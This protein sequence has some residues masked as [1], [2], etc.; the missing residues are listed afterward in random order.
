MGSRK[1]H[2]PSSARLSGPALF[3]AKRIRLLSLDP[4]P[5]DVHEGVVA[6]KVFVLRPGVSHH[7]SKRAV[8]DVSGALYAQAVLEERCAKLDEIP[9]VQLIQAHMA[10]PPQDMFA[11][12]LA[13]VTFLRGT[14]A[15]VFVMIHRS[16]YAPTV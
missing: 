2:F 9:S 15:G 12:V 7:G 16:K 4:W 1:N 10:K 3:Y 11:E 14:V 8:D 13:V 5:L 6:L